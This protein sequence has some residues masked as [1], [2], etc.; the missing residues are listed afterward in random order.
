MVELPGGVTGVLRSECLPSLSSDS[1]AA[2]RYSGSW[3]VVVSSGGDTSLNSAGGGNSL[4]SPSDELS[5]CVVVMVTE[6]MVTELTV[7]GCDGGSGICSTWD[8]T[9]LGSGTLAAAAAET[10]LHK[11]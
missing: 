3:L 10:K 9:G 5:V 6:S 2:F 7:S 11:H 8:T 1:S 4:V